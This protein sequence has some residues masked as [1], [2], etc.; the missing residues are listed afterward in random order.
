MVLPLSEMR[1][2][3]ALQFDW[4]LCLK[5]IPLAQT[6][7]SRGLVHM[8][9]RSCFKK[10]SVIQCVQVLEQGGCDCDNRTVKRNYKDGSYGACGATIVE[11]R[12]GVLRGQQELGA[13]LRF[14]PARM[15][16]TQV[17]SSFKFE[18]HTCESVFLADGA[19]PK[20][21]VC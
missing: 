12:I 6:S 3:S 7:G 8:V 10:L 18:I 2:F 20:R 16:T 13:N 1:S 21:L 19:V 5:V 15:C 4:D 11:D 9:K 17:N 14:T